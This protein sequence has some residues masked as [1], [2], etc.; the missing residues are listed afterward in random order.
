MQHKR[1]SFCMSSSKYYTHANNTNH[2]NHGRSGELN[3][4]ILT[5][6]QSMVLQH[7][8]QLWCSLCRSL[9]GQQ[10]PC[11]NGGWNISLLMLVQALDIHKHVLLATHWEE[12]HYQYAS[13]R[14]QNGGTCTI[15]FYMHINPTCVIP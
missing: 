8:L 10:T 2:L 9:S 13:N 6:N 7:M 15:K 3:L 11:L 12:L 14:C 4:P 5:A 1:S